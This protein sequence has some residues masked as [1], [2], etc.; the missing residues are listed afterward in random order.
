M[1]TSSSNSS[2]SS[3]STPSILPFLQQ[4]AQFAQGLAQQTYSWASGEFQKDSQLTDANV[5]SYLAT[6]A[7]A[8][9][10]AQH[11]T[12]RYDNLFQP[13]ENN[14]ITDAN[15]YSST[16]RQ[17]ADA[18]SAEAGVGQ[19]MDAGRKNAERDLQAYG[20]DPSSGR[21]DELEQASQAQKGAAQAG[22]GQEAVRADQATGRALR[23]E[24]IQVGERYPGQIINSM[25]TAM[26]GFSGAENARLSNTNTAANAFGTAAPFIKF[27]PVSNTSTSEQRSAS[28]SNSPGQSGSNKPPSSGGK[29]GGSGSGSGS[30]SKSGGYNGL[31]SGGGANPGMVSNPSFDAGT[32]PDLD[33]WSQYPGQYDPT[34]GG[35]YANDGVGVDAPGFEPGAG[36]DGGQYA[37]DQGSGAASSS[38]GGYYS[39]YGGGSTSG[40]TGGG[41]GGGGY[42]GGGFTGGGYYAKGGAV[43]P[44]QF[45]GGVSPNQSPSGGAATD[46]VQMPIAGGAGRA[47]LN[48]DEFVIPKDVAKWK[49]QEFFQKLIT[50]SRQ[51]R[52]GAPA[53]PKAGPAGAGRPQ[54]SQQMGH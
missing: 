1:S 7:A 30:G 35:T 18:G 16:A 37:Y 42:G 50:Q 48:V 34:T 47:H 14:L 54:V 8:L 23:S 31:G 9:S 51:A 2:G 36:S 29:P 11:D 22:A 43:S 12:S 21:Y 19:S 32:P 24:A 49:G 25:N 39:N 40:D 53:K 13:Q 3:S 20:I 41:Y 33:D 26:Q 5:Q 4:L 44:G 17:Q 28:G 15:T 45:A 38:N 52:I 46:D 10:Q 27:P 6:S